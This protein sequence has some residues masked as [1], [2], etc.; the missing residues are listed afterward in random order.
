MK[1]DVRGNVWTTAADGV[2]VYSP[3][4]KLLETIA[5]PEQPA[6][7]AFGGDD[8]KTLYVTARQGL[9]RVRTTVPGIAPGRR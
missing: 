6:N 2:R 5:F 1:V 9:Y 7:C 3:A 4:G 8:Y